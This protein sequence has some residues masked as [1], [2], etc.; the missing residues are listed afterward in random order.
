MNTNI[1]IAK[2]K[3][4]ALGLDIH[5]CKYDD[6][7]RRSNKKYFI[8]HNGRKIYFGSASNEDFTVHK[9]KKRRDLYRARH[10]KIM[11]LHN[12]RLVPAYTVKYTPSWLSWN[13]LW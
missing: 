6:E 4:A 13:I 7:C 1:D 3:A 11:M 12:G 5:P 10:S 9:D 8:I 2:K